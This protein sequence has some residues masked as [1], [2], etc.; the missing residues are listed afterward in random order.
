[1][2][3]CLKLSLFTFFTRDTFS[4]FL[5][6]RGEWRGRAVD[7]WPSPWLSAACRTLWK[8]GVGHE[9][10]TSPDRFRFVVRRASSTFTPPPPSPSTFL[11]FSLPPRRHQPRHATP[12]HATPLPQRPIPCF[13]LLRGTA[14]LAHK[15]SG[16]CDWDRQCRGGVAWR[17]VAWLHV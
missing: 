17:R 15:I 1:M 16:T 5:F 10:R 4:V 6:S 2:T 14:C 12:R 9:G 8:W 13:A 11:F 3:K 7:P